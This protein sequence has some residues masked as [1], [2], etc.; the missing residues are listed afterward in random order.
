M[1]RYI[2][3]LIL[4]VA[5]LMLPA[6]AQVTTGIVTGTVTDQ[7]GVKDITKSLFNIYP[8]PAT[9]VL[10][11]DVLQVG[12]TFLQYQVFS[13]DGKCIDKGIMDSTHNSLSVSNY[14]KGLY[15]IAIFNP[16]NQQAYFLQ[17]IKG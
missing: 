8:Q 5:C 16:T 15:I 11:F 7:T 4:C 6:Y 1:R 14:N 12:N 13:I 9:D 2:V 10:N 3:S 17:W